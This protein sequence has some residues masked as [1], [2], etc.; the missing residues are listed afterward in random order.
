MEFWLFF[1]MFA[2]AVVAMVWSALG[3]YA[4][5]TDRTRRLRGWLLWLGYGAAAITF[6]LLAF[7]VSYKLRE[8]SIKVIFGRWYM[9]PVVLP[10]LVASLVAAM[11]TDFVDVA[12]AALLAFSM[13][14][15]L[16]FGSWV[17][18]SA[19]HDHVV[20]LWCLLAFAILSWACLLLWVMPLAV[21]W[22][23]LSWFKPAS[24]AGTGLER[25]QNKAWY[26]GVS[27]VIWAA[28][29]LYILFFAL[30]PEAF[31]VYPGDAGRQELISS[32]LIMFVAD[33]IV[34]IASIVAY[35]YLAGN[36]DIALSTPF[37]VFDSTT[38]AD[39]STMPILSHIG[40]LMG[41][42]AKQQTAQAG[43]P[44]SGL[45]LSA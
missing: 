10:A 34:G 38:L 25:V 8:D 14:M 19:G 13:A 29:G 26:G 36:G 31:S 12:G 20:R 28:L 2:A 4:T 22:S 16:M 3:A 27:F 9:Y 18:S 1:I 40:G 43:S 32:A 42:P 41:A 6:F 37:Q 33:L 23:L 44:L 24:S 30:S 11:S 21:G 7:R 45:Q 5:L 35:S 15:S 39:A 17:P